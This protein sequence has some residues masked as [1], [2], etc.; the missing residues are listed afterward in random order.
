MYK[1][2]WRRESRPLWNFITREFC[3]TLQKNRFSYAERNQNKDQVGC[4]K[5]EIDACECEYETKI[6]LLFFV[7]NFQS[8]GLFPIFDA[9]LL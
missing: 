3:V 7:I 2:K 6:I 1:E 5:L 4:Y 8:N 9:L